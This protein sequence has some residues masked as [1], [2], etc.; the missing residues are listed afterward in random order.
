LP[1]YE[2][3]KITNRHLT[4]LPTGPGD[5]S[6][7]EFGPDRWGHFASSY[8]EAGDALVDAAEASTYR[9]NTLGAPI[10]FSYRQ[11]IELSLKSLL[12]AAG[13]LLD[14]EQTVEPK[15]Y[16][17][18]L[19]KRVRALLLGVDPTSEGSWLQRADQIIAE[20]DA[21]DPNSFCF[22]YPVDRG[23]APALGGP[24]TIHPRTRE[25]VDELAIILE[26]ADAQID[27]FMGFKHEGI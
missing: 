24:L 15:H 7:I 20:F 8:R 9:R 6:S 26:G 10:L 27:H 11:Y 25:V 12:L 21:L 16:L 19:W 2:P 23:G 13:E 18:I 3:T 4:D 5:G 1:R 22:R 17:A 14:D